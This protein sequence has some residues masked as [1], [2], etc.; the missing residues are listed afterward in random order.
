MC[1]TE[2]I[3]PKIQSCITA[4]GTGVDSVLAAVGPRGGPRGCCRH[5][6]S[7]LV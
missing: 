6:V 1:Q 7:K 2:V 4:C 3:K 5:A